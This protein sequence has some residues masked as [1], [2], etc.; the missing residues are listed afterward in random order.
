MSEKVY[1]WF[2]FWVANWLASETVTCMSLA[3][4][5]AYIHLL[6]HQW[7]SSDCTIP[8]DEVR[9]AKL[10]NV[11][12]V[13]FKEIWVELAEC[14]P[15]S[16]S[17]RRQN[18]RLKA[19]LEKKGG[20]TKA[21]QDNARSRW[22]KESEQKPTKKRTPKKAEDPKPVDQVSGSPG[23]PFAKVERVLTLASQRIEGSPVQRADIMRQIRNESPVRLLLDLF[24]EDQVV[25]MYVHAVKNWRGGASW[26]AVHAQR[27]AIIESMRSGGRKPKGE[28]KEDKF[29][30]LVSEGEA[31]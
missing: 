19:E 16:E 13:E 14:F 12:P 2:S 27:D 15:V 24:P 28:T 25:E 26:S 7:N 8:D 29:K 6:C 3:G 22:S 5:G 1:P 9:L 31:A 30:R 20:R 18:V 21:A 4:R 17:G 11:T 10:L 23:T